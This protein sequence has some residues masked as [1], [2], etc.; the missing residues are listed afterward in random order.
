M[1]TANL[2]AKASIATKSILS[3]TEGKRVFVR[4]DFNVPISSDGRVESDLRLRSALPTLRLLL[5]EGGAKLLILASHLGRPGGK[6]KPE[7]SLLPVANSLRDLLKK[8]YET[9][10]AKNFKC[11]TVEFVQDCIGDSVAKAV[12]KS[13]PHSILLLENLRFYPEEEAGKNITEEQQMNFI[14]QLFAHSDLFVNDAFGTA[15]RAHSSMVGF[16]KLYKNDSKKLA[17]SGLLMARELKN[18][19]VILEKPEKPV[20]CIVG[21][22]KVVDKCK[23]LLNLLQISDTLIICGGLAYPFL[24][25]VY[26]KKIGKFPSPPESEEVVKAV[27]DEAKKLGVKILL[28]QDF[29]CAE[30]LESEKTVY[31][32]GEVLDGML[33]LDCGEKSNKEFEKAIKESKTIL[34][35]GPPGV[36][37][38]K[39]FES[40][41][42]HMLNAICSSNAVK[43]AGGGDT[44][45][46]VLK[47]AKESSFDL[48]STGGGASLEL[49]EGKVLPGVA[50]LSE[51]NT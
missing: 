40:G 50:A 11:P 14:K 43:V 8:D 10:N 30:S 24:K 27:A 45:N 42:I 34:W 44:T 38:K 2:S 21:G 48:V 26:N 15:H 28:P 5:D 47:M 37:E 4:V 17:V 33:G 18:F 13:E 12:E 41:S 51:I 36:F 35:N 19:A 16:S 25:V 7:L 6:V 49:L 29:V 1:S 23:L 39:P 32:D 22:A 20:M 46:L 3:R 9:N 31:S